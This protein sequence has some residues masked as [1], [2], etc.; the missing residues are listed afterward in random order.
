M[1]GRFAKNQNA[2]EYFG[3]GPE[4]MKEIKI[5]L[6]CGAMLK[7]S[8]KVCFACGNN[9]PAKTLFD[10][11]KETHAYCLNCNAILP[12]DAKYCPQCGKK[13]KN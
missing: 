8:D 6:Y 10:R 4:R 3:F 2:R 11:Y 13:I 9:V 5:C 7:D 12:N 1:Q